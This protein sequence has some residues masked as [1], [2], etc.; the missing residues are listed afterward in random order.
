MSISV[1]WI[2]ISL[3]A[4]ASL[5][6]SGCA[7]LIKP[8]GYVSPDGVSI[9]E[10]GRAVYLPKNAPS[11]SQGY[12]PE[13]SSGNNSGGHEG[14][15]IFGKTNTPVISP[16]TGTVI[17]SYFEPIYGNCIVINH[18]KNE[19]NLFLRSRFLHLKKRL[20]K[21][22]DIVVRGQQIGTLGRTG[23][24]A[25]G[26]PHLHYEI[27]AGT[28]RDQLLFQPLNPHRF[29]MDGVGVVTCFDSSRQYADL[30]FRTTYPVPCRGV[31]WQ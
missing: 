23:L 19:N 27:R 30:P 31:D 5:T 22:G 6:L 16:A 15:D 1:F 10:G 20:V 26:F 25:G 28:K 3:I 21:K 17:K 9:Q 13:P 29:W 8:Y 2:R 4:V 24:L 7:R 12:N 14:I 18:G 11:I